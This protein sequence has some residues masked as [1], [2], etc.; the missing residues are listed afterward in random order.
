MEKIDYD[1]TNGGFLRDAKYSYGLFDF[2]KKYTDQFGDAESV[3]VTISEEIPYGAIVSFTKNPI[4]MSE[5]GKNVKIKFSASKFYKSNGKEI[6]KP[7][8]EEV[9]TSLGYSMDNAVKV[10]ADKFIK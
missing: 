2:F 4:I 8:Q 10:Y 6:R 5:D 1:N 3:S 9:F 7:T